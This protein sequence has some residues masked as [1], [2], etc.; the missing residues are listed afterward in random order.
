MRKQVPMAEAI[1]AHIAALEQQVAALRGEMQEFTQTISHDLRAPLRHIVAYTQLVQEDAGPGLNA[2]VQG[3]LATITDSARHLDSQ[4]DALAALSRIGTVPVTLSPVALQPLV[5]A[6]CSELAEKHPLRHIQWTALTELPT[7]QA[8]AKLLRQVLVNV[9]DNA[10]KFTAHQSAPVIS[11]SAAV[12]DDGWVTLQVQDNGAGYNPAMQG[13]LF[14][15]F[16]RL[17]SAKQFAGLGMGLVQ[18]RKALQRMGGTVRAEG[19][20]DGGCC[21][22]MVLPKA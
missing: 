20:V 22:T 17:H 18:T 1:D 12:S 11:L 3:F 5:Q 6:I 9:L 8:D 2:E 16:G 4:M 19:I 14:K 13:E 10:A 15:V 21:V 7:V